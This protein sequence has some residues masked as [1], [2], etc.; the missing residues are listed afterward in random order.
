V[1]ARYQKEID[2]LNENLGRHNQIKKFELTGDEWSPLTGELSPT[3]KLRRK[4]IKEKYR[5]EFDRLY[6]YA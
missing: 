6:G 2:K 4:E 1:L 5:A 3:L